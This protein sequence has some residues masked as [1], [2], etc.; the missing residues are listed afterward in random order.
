ML[1]LVPWIVSILVG[2]VVGTLGHLYFS[3]QR[4]RHKKDK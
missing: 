1:D 4:R 2:V 3:D